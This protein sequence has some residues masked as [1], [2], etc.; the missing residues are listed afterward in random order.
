MSSERPAVAGIA[1]VRARNSIASRSAIGR[2]TL[3]RHAGS[4]SSGRDARLRGEAA[5]VH[6]A[7][8]AGGRGGGREAL[9]GAAVASGEVALLAGCGLHRVDEVIGDRAAV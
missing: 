5:E 9:G 7:L 8:D 2:V 6:H 4:G 1:A 3:S